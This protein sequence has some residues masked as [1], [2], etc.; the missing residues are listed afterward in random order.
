MIQLLFNSSMGVDIQETSVSLVYVKGSFKGVQWVDAKRMLFD[1]SKPLD[2][3][4]DDAAA[5]V[6]GFM[7]D[8]RISDAM[9]FIAFPGKHC[10]L[11]EVEFPWAVKENLRATLA[12][13]MEKYIPLAVDD[14]YF[15][16]QIVVE[17][18]AKKH[19]KVMIGVVKKE[20]MGPYLEVASRI[21]RG[22]S[23]IESSFAALANYILYDH[24][25][26]DGPAMG[27]WCRET[28]FDIIYMDHGALV[29][30]RSVDA[31]GPAAEWGAQILHHTNQIR[32]MFL[33][34]SQAAKLCVYGDASAS[35]GL[36]EMVSDYGYIWVPAMLQGGAVSDTAFIPAAGLALRGL[37]RLPVQLNFMP[38]NLRKKPDKTSLF[39]LMGLVV[40]LAVSGTLWAVTHVMTRQAMMEKMDQELARLKL[41]AQEVE[42]IQQDIKSIQ[43]KIGFLASR[44]PGHVYLAD[45]VKELS[46]RIPTT[47]WIRELKLSGNQ[48][49]LYGS[50]D[51]ASELIPLL[52]ASPI[53]SDVKFQ[54]TIRKS[55]EDKEVFRIG[56]TIVA[57]GSEGGETP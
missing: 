46:E 54:S 42:T 8:H 52:E 1:P 30:G 4:M 51:S 13:E 37:C 16:H 6:N 15:D 20:D 39:I 17:D 34:N 9:V 3:R 47:A 49:T 44:R 27:V 43:D 5:F 21:S 29:Y 50:A 19:L 22:V 18:K 36:S 33:K 23:G 10:V 35:L 45:I 32:N 55:K 56:L 11:R 38:E 57:P 28:G 7:Q 2:A 24:T 31:D 40:L 26:G 41:E 53:F 25:V 48:L 14:V 12:Y